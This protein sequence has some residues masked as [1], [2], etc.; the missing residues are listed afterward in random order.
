MPWDSTVL[1]V[2]EDAADGDMRI[3]AY[4]RPDGKRVIVLSNRC[5]AD[6]RFDVATN[7]PEARWV[8]RRYTPDTAG[9][10]FAGEP[11][12]AQRGDLSVTVADLS[13]EF[14]IEA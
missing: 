10:D 14:W 7:L 4:A 8:G 11:I 3:L 6:V 13:W 5:G 2:E 1:S 9:N 12:G